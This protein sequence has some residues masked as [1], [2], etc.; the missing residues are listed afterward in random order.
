MEPLPPE[1]K[2]AAVQPQQPQMREFDDIAA[3]RQKIY[4][5][6]VNAIQDKYSAMENDR[7]QVRISNLGYRGKDQFD[8]D[9]QKAALLKRKSLNRPLHGTWELVD[10]ATGDVVDSKE[11][12]VA[13]VPHLTERGT[14]I[15]NGTEYTVANQMR[16]RPGVYTRQKGNGQFEAHFNLMPGT[17]KAFR[18]HMDPESG[19]FKMQVGQANIPLYPIL[20]TMGVPD[21]DLEKWWGRDLLT[22][23]RAKDD[24][25]AFGKLYKRMFPSGAAANAGDRI[26]QVQNEFERMRLDPD[27]VGRSLGTYLKP[28]EPAP[29]IEPASPA[30]TSE[31]AVD[32]LN[33][34]T[35][36]EDIPPLDGLKST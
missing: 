23:N 28:P 11:A 36:T 25:V 17:G 6:V 12:I 4:D 5:N 21:K 27:V 9:A 19:V 3:M 29:I 20:R 34:G 16:L 35:E 30:P 7:Y 22:A 18:V 26:R 31:K 10:K 24:D 1:R 8:F 13:H 2:E 32:M 33:T 15:Q 14:F